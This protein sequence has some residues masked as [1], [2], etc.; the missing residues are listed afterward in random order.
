MRNTILAGN[1][2][3]MFSDLDGRLNSS[4]YN[5][6]EA[7]VGGF[8][9]DPT[10]LLGVDPLLSPLQ[11]NGGPTQTMALLPGSPALNAGDPDQLGLPDQRGVVRSGGVNIG[12]YQASATAFALTAP[13]AVTAGVPFD[14]TVTALDPF[15]QV[16]V[17]YTGTADLYSTDAAAPFLGEHAFSLA[18][19]G[20]YT[21]AGVTLSTAGPQ[22][23]YAA[24]A[25]GL[26]GSADLTVSAG[27]APGAPGGARTGVPARGAGSGAVGYA[28]TSAGPAKDALPVTVPSPRN[29]SRFVPDPNTDAVFGGLLFLMVSP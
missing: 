17:G 26:Y 25:G 15:G 28:F 18:D 2:A 23:L 27:D 11:D 29:P 9:F 5:L 10:D 20:S 1:T 7:P 4:G 16:A 22:T 8:G 24:D 21:F 13:D 12:A 19:G 3:R 6:V 14:V